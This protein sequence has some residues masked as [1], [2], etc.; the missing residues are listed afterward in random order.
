MALLILG[1]GG[2]A[3]YLYFMHPAEASVGKNQTNANKA[4]TA[5]DDKSAFVQMD[6]LILPIIGSGGITETVSL[7]IV[8][9]VPDEKSADT[10]KKLTPLLKDAYIQDM[11]G[12]LNKRNAMPDGVIQ[13]GMIKDRLNH[14][15]R[16]VLGDEVVKNVL[17]QVVQQHPI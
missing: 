10:V 1:G 14:V 2:A 11:Y 16:Q 7:V 15:S 9:E 12:V 13:V 4:E 6:P 5:A 3:A 8:I 17:L